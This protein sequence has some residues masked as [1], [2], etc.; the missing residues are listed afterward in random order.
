MRRWILLA[1]ALSLASLSTARADLDIG[2]PPGAPLSWA[3]PRPGPSGR[4]AALRGPREATGDAGAKPGKTKVRGPKAR[5]KPAPRQLPWSPAGRETSLGFARVITLDLVEE[6]AWTPYPRGRAAPPTGGAAPAIPEGAPAASWGPELTGAYP[7]AI[8]EGLYWYLLAPFL[9]QV[10]HPNLL[11]KSETLAYLLQAGS[12]VR[13]ITENLKTHPKAINMK[14]QFR[15][16]FKAIDAGIPELP[17]GRPRPRLSDDPHEAALLRFAALELAAGYA[18]DFEEPLAPR[19]RALPRDQAIPL[20]AAYAHPGAHPLLQ[21]NAVALLSRYPDAAAGAALKT[22]HEQCSD[23]VARRRAFLAL[24][25]RGDPSARGAA[26]SKTLAKDDETR[27]LGLHALGII[28]EAADQD[29]IERLLERERYDLILAAA[30]ALARLPGVDRRRAAK[31]LDA[32]RRKLRSGL[33]ITLDARPAMTPDIAS[34]KGIKLAILE[35]ALEIA[36]ARLGDRGAAARLLKLLAAPP[37]KVRVPLAFRGRRL[38][39]NPRTFGRVPFPTVAFLIESLPLLGKAGVKRLKI[40]RDDAIC[41]PALR[42]ASLA[43]LGSALTLKAKDLDGFFKAR[44]PSLQVGALKALYRLDPAAARARAREL[45]VELRPAG[46]K[47]KRSP[48]SPP[49]ALLLAALE[50]LEL[51]GEEVR[52][53]TLVSAY[54]KMAK[55]PLKRRRRAPGAIAVIESGGDPLSAM[56]R[57]LGQEGSEAAGEVLAAHL[58][59]GGLRARGVAALQLGRVVGRGSAAALIDGLADR[60][61]WVRLA[62]AQSLRNFPGQESVNR[63]IDWLDGAPDDRD[64]AVKRYRAWLDSQ[65]WKSE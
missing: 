39:A 56:L 8:S 47:G 7:P 61:A 52:A 12:P 6:I 9:R 3:S 46:K 58:K 4:A 64:A 45:L 34:P 50:V 19:L 60:D 25:E 22:A 28:G 53:L 29:I 51:G 2:T 5:P 42:L 40:I 36:S 57:A 48:K 21:Q 62:C 44:D 14:S 54:E 1:A 43:A 65:P 27:V 11:L 35:A 37:V 63:D 38:F 24:A 10:L 41:E 18:A 15:G 59:D 13:V 20:L 32:V 17:G 23:P 16:W 33:A 55:K 31:A 30:R 26:R 49:P